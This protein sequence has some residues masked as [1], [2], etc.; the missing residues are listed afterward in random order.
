MSIYRRKEQRADNNMGHGTHLRSAGPNGLQSSVGP[1]LVTNKP[2]PVGSRSRKQRDIVA[3]NCFTQGI[4]E[5]LCAKTYTE[6]EL[7]DKFVMALESFRNGRKWNSIQKA[8]DIPDAIMDQLIAFS[9][10]IMA[11]ADRDGCPDEEELRGLARGAMAF[12]ETLQ[13]DPRRAR[14]PDGPQQQQMSLWC[15]KHAEPVPEDEEGMEKEVSEFQRFK[16][17]IKSFKKQYQSPYGAETL[18]YT[19]PYTTMKK[20]GKF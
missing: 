10:R 16:G 19:S 20:S 15:G 3:E 9:C 13:E 12:Y 11:D 6:E 4:R 1:P 5:S 18:S 2:I 14:A 7:A 8:M 17:S